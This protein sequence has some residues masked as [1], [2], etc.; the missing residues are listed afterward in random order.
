MPPRKKLLLAKIVP[1]VKRLGLSTPHVREA[2]NEMGVLHFEKLA[3]EPVVAS[4]A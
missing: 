1:N 4:S 2:W 3:D